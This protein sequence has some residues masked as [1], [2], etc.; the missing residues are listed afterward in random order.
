MATIR[1]KYKMAAI[2]AICSSPEMM[3]VVRDKAKVKDSDVETALIATTATLADILIAEDGWNVE[4]H[5]KNTSGKYE[6]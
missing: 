5:M 3:K 2:K 6:N 1:Q 4:Y